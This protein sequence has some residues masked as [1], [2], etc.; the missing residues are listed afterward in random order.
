MRLSIFATGFLAFMLVALLTSFTPAQTVNKDG[1][2]T[3]TSTVIDSTATV[4]STA[5]SLNDWTG[6]FSTWPLTAEVFGTTTATGT[7]VTSNIIQGGMS[8]TG[9]WSNVDTIAVND[10]LSTTPLSTTVDLNGWEYP[11]Y[12]HKVTGAATNHD[13]TYVDIKLFRKRK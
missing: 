9:P 10:T 6:S 2:V 11:F 3:F 12:R 1:V 7:V 13:S 4:Y 8:R 5:F